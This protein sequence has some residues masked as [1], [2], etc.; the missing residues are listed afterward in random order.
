MAGL[1]SATRGRF[2]KTA[3]WTPAKLLLIGWVRR[4]PAVQQSTC[5][6]IKR[7]KN[8]EKTKILP[9]FCLFDFGNKQLNGF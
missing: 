7:R 9:V 1:P 4:T 3:P 5:F 2:C 6:S 8:E